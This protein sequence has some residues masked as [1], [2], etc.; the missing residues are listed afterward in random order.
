MAAMLLH[1]L[2]PAL[3]L[4]WL[5]YWLIAARNAKPIRKRERL[6][7]RL[8][9]HLPLAAVVALL[10]LPRFMPAALTEQFLPRD[11]GLVL[12]G[13]IMVA[14]GLALAIWARHHLGRNWSGLAALKIDHT[15]IRSGPYRSVRHPIYTGLLLAFL[16]MALAIG[17]WRA[18]LAFALVLPVLLHRSRL[19]EALMREAFPA[20]YDAYR[21][22][23]WTLLPYI[24]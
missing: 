16:G 11:S 2:I 23:S 6:A 1:I 17:E 21:R 4:L 3:W 12:L 5:A 22:E 8:A 20:D 10:A 19:E 18:L 24:F 15:L 13:T 7:W 9:H 14:A